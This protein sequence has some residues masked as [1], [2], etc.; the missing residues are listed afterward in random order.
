MGDDACLAEGADRE[1]IRYRVPSAQRENTHTF[2]RGSRRERWARCVITCYKGRIKG[3][4]IG[5]GSNGDAYF[6]TP[7]ARVSAALNVW[8]RKRSE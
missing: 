6:V 7:G 2:L 8:K 3:V 5:R 4:G 1:P